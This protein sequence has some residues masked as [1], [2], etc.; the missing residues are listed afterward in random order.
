MNIPVERE[1]TR[2]LIFPDFCPGTFREWAC[3]QLH[4]AEFDYEAAREAVIKAMPRSHTTRTHTHTHTHTRTRTHT[5]T[6]THAHVHTQHTH[7]AMYNGKCCGV[8]V[9]KLEH[10]RDYFRYKSNLIIKYTLEYKDTFK[11]KNAVVWL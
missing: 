11:K 10:H 3:E 2:A 9:G 8:V 4:A 1:N 7:M 6:H 5:H